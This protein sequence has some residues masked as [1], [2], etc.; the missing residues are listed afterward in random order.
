MHAK[1]MCTHTSCN[2]ELHGIVFTMIYMIRILGT[3]HFAGYVGSTNLGLL[4]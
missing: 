1:T 3:G 2:P 4:V